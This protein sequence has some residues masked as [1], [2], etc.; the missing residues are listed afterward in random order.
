MDMNHAFGDILS[1]SFFARRGLVAGLLLRRAFGLLFFFCG[2]VGFRHNVLLETTNLWMG[3][4]S[5]R[6]RSFAAPCGCAR[7]C[8]SA[9][10]A[11]ASSCD[12]A[13]RGSTPCRDG[14][15]Y[16]SPFHD[17]EPHRLCRLDRSTG[18]P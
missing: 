5:S 2:F 17:A 18:G 16:S 13:G 1:P 12:D 9:V 8:G 11:P 3:P 6:R 10:R 7:W 4:P 15:C 14:A